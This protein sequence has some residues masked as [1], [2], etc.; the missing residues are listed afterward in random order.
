MQLVFLTCSLYIFNTTHYLTVIIIIMFFKLYKQKVH[1]IIALT[2]PNTDPAC[3]GTALCSS[4]S[5]PQNS[6]CIQENNH[7]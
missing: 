3:P 5:V 7:H 2:F 6:L 1:K 4:S